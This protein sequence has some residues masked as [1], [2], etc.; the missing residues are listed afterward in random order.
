MNCDTNLIIA[1]TTKNHTAKGYFWKNKN[2]TTDIMEKIKA[3]NNR[4]DS[5]KKGIK[6]LNKND[7]S[8]IAIFESLTDAANSLGSPALR[9]SIGRVCAGKQKTAGGYKWAYIEE[10]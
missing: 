1:A 3:Y 4:Y 5:R 6:Q 8:V 9:S 7:N 10:I 2:D